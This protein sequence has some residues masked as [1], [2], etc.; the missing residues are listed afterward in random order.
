MRRYLLSLEELKGFARDF[1]TFLHPAREDYDFGAMIEVRR[2]NRETL[3]SEL[4]EKFRT[5]NE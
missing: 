3:V 2:D 4:S 5:L 1:K